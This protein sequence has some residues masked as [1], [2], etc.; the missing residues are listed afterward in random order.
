MQWQSIITNM[1]S[2]R[3][4]ILSHDPWIDLL[5]KALADLKHE[6]HHVEINTYH[7]PQDAR[8]KILG[9]KPDFT[10]GRNYYDFISFHNNWSDEAGIEFKNLLEASQIPHA[11]WYLDSPAASGN[12]FLRKK[13]LSGYQPNGTCFFVTDRQD[14]SFFHKLSL[15]TAHLPMAAER[16]LISRQMNQ[17][18]LT[19]YQTDLAFVGTPPPASGHA[20]I[21]FQSAQAVA[22]Y[23]ANLDG[24]KLF[25]V[26]VAMK[27]SGY[28]V[29]PTQPQILEKIGSAFFNFYTTFHIAPVEYHRERARLEKNIHQL[30]GI[31]KLPIA[32]DYRYSYYQLITSLWHFKKK[33]IRVYGGPDWSIWLG[34]YQ[35]HYPRLPFDTELP[36]FLRAAKILFCLTK[37]QYYGAV[38]DRPL[39]T[40]VCGGFPL[41]DHREEIDD[42]F[43]PGE[44]VTYHSIE[45]AD[46]LVDY[47]LTHESERREVIQKG[48]A[49]VLAN[50]TYHHRAL[51]LVRKMSDH[52]SL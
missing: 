42:S 4:A 3:I 11:S 33:G 31:A 7:K 52:F 50:H 20:A 35:S 16:D 21:S 24:Q 36:E 37:W 17:D 9:L 51:D 8:D 39:M 46:Q 44:I 28:D 2:L 23:Y 49:R 12:L 48:Q 30:T 41:T 34:N 6:V 1:K 32:I 5:G 45:E 22:A 47:Y 29:P 13:W 38:H 26:M 10:L 15:P 18:K 27:N 14:M 19:H 25:E 43:R 40:L